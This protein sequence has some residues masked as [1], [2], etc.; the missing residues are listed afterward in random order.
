MNSTIY[1]I[2]YCFILMLFLSCEITPQQEKPILSESTSTTLPTQPYLVVLGIAQDA[3]FPQAACQKSCCADAWQQPELRKSVS[4]IALV[5]PSSQQYWIFDAT[6]NFKTQL[7]R[8]SQHSKEVLPQGIFLTHGHVGHY[9]GLT[10]LGREIMGAKQVPVYTM[11][12]MKDYLSNNG[13]WSLLVDL[14]NISLRTLKADSTI[15][16]TNDIKVTPL[17]VPHRDEFTETVGYKIE[18]S[19]KSALFIPDIDKW[20]KW[21]RDIRQLITSVDIA[22]IDGSFYENG[23]IPGRDMS[24]IPHP[25]IVESMDLLRD[26]SAKDKAKVHFIHF[27]HT[28]P[29][30][31][32]GSLARKTILK[33]GFKWATEGMVFSF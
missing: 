24:E 17:L 4:C 30:L 11:P 29:V 5:E 7:Q 32:E 12:R 26:L 14:E 20:Q 8:M 21:D 25:F 10:H 19:N 22:L 18:C 6:P 31:Q 23:E 2:F 16:L 1:L 33:K 9:T 3:G 27:N 28:N 13:P 15:S